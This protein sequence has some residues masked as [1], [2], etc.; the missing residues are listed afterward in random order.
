[1]RRILLLVFASLALSSISSPA[2]ELEPDDCAK[3]KAHLCAKVRTMNCMT[4]L[5]TTAVERIDE[6]CGVTESSRFVA[7]VVDYCQG[8]G[9]FSAETCEG[10]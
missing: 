2:C 1:M 10:S 7:A 5:M 4:G 6:A 3:A 9:T 8:S